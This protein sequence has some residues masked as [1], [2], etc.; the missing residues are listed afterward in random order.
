M[1]YYIHYARSL[2]LFVSIWCTCRLI[3]NKFHALCNQH[4]LMWDKLCDNEITFLAF[5]PYV[6]HVYFCYSLVLLSVNIAF[7]YGTYVLRDVVYYFSEWQICDRNKIDDIH[8]NVISDK[9]ARSQYVYLFLYAYI[10]GSA[11]LYFDIRIF[12]LV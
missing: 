11:I 2:W 1:V 5:L 12:I 10:R 8:G 4:I 3:K 6:R 7:L 9:R